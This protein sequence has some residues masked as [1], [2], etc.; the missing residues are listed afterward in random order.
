MHLNITKQLLQKGEFDGELNEN[1]YQAKKSQSGRISMLLKMTMTKLLIISA[2]S[3]IKLRKTP[4]TT[5]ILS[6]KLRHTHRSAKS[7]LL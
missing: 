3:L 6:G 5:F 1:F 7:F 4:R 2:L